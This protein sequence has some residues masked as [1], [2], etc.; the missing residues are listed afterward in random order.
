MVRYAK[1]KRAYVVEKLRGG[2]ADNIPLSSFPK[3][4]LRKGIAV[5]KEHTSNKK[6]QKEIAKDHLAEDSRYYS[7]LEKMEK[8]AGSLKAL[9]NFIAKVKAT[10]DAKKIE[11]STDKFRQ[12][13]E[14]LKRDSFTTGFKRVSEGK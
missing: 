12:M 2:L 8:R 11:K 14:A 3:K 13:R 9:R 7:K 10:A 4:E 6:I 5:E 1:E